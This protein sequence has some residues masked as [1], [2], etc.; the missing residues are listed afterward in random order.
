MSAASSVIRNVASGVARSILDEVDGGCR[1]VVG[2]FD[3]VDD[4]IELTIDG[5]DFASDWRLTWVSNMDVGASDGCVF[6]SNGTT[7]GVEFQA[8]GNIRIR[9]SIGVTTIP[10]AN[11]GYTLGDWEQ[12]EITWDV[13]ATTLAL[14]VGETQVWSDTSFSETG[15]YG[16]LCIGALRSTVVSTPFKG[17]IRQV[18]FEQNGVVR[19]Y[20][21]IDDDSGDV[22]NAAIADVSGNG[23]DG[24]LDNN[25]ASTFWEKLPC[26]EVL[27]LGISSMTIGSSFLIG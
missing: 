23:N 17:S 4:H 21:P 27:S 22:D 18:E 10:S 16:A 5:P 20:W 2:H 14:K 12:F 8:N 1:T 25:N 26:S 13:S 7:Y 9:G 6:G 3:G 24:V 15:A 11:V 19:G